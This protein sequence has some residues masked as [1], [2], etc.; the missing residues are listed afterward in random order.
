MSAWRP[1]LPNADQWRLAG[2]VTVLVAATFVHEPAILAVALL[3]GLVLSG[4]SRIAL[5]RRGLRAVLPVAAL[6]SAGVLL[7]GAWQGRF[8]LRFLALFNVRVLFLGT[9]VAWIAREVDLDRAL[10][11]W[12]VARRWLAI[13]RVQTATLQR[14]LGDYQAAFRSRS[15]EPPS[16]RV[17]TR[18]VATHG[19]GLLD[20]A[21]H[22][23][24]YVTRAMRSRG[25][26]DD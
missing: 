6:V 3:A 19:L 22:E 25:A 17:R 14:A 9:L 13:V 12:P 21:V 2:A 1:D 20:K 26:L 4:P 15:A 16:L 11:P 24:E 23:A 5:L 7:A 10:A 18:A 8:D